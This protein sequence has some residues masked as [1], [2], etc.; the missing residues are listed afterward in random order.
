MKKSELFFS[1]LQIPVDYL[2]ILLAGATVYYWR[3]SARML[4]LYP[5]PAG[6]IIPRGQ[7]ARI[8]LVVAIFFYFNVRH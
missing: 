1:A 7:Y 4:E 8:I 6:E 5:M 3:F 2:M